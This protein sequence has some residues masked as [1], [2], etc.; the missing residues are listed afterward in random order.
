MRALHGWALLQVSSVDMYN[1]LLGDEKFSDQNHLRFPAYSARSGN[2]LFFKGFS[3]LYPFI[4]FFARIHI[5][6]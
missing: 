5:Q 1:L 2:C 6:P 3:Y 4:F